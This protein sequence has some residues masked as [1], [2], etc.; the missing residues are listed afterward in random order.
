MMKQGEIWTGGKMAGWDP[1]RSQPLYFDHKAL[2]LLRSQSDG[3][4]LIR[5]SK[6]DADAK[7]TNQITG[8]R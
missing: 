4:V 8:R 5:E 2:S 6:K 3:V 7:I 1:E